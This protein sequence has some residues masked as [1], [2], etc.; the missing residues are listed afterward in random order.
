LKVVRNLAVNLLG[1]IA[2][3][4]NLDRQIRHDIPGGFTGHNGCGPAGIGHEGNI[5]TT[6]EVTLRIQDEKYLADRQAQFFTHGKIIEQR[7]QPRR[8]HRLKRPH[9]LSLHAHAINDFIPLDVVN[10]DM[11]LL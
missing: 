3:T 2:W 10:R 9:R 8:Q 6:P 1:K 7:T 4:H 5:G 11:V